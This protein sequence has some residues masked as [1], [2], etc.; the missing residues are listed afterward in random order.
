MTIQQKNQ[1]AIARM[2]SAPVPTT[3]ANVWAHTPASYQPP[4]RTKVMGS[5]QALAREAARQGLC[6]SS[7]HK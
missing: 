2:A 3:T 1:I 6:P 7:N 4:H 5:I